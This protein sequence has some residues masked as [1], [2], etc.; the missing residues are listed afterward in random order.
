MINSK[1]KISRINRK[2]DK[3][4]YKEETGKTNRYIKNRALRK[5]LS[6]KLAVLGLFFVL[7]VI[8][9]S[10]FAPFVCRHDPQ[11]VNLRKILKR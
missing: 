1:N 10:I 8:I 2:F 11:K 4:K 9:S 3:I 6:N 5:M 7:I